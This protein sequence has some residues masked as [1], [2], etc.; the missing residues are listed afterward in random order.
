MNI[1]FDCEYIFPTNFTASS[2]YPRSFIMASTRALSI[3]AEAFLKSMYNRY[4][5]SV[6]NCASSNAAINSCNCLDVHLK[7]YFGP[8]SSI[9][10]LYLFYYSSYVYFLQIITT[11][12]I[13]SIS[14]L[15]TLNLEL[16]KFLLLMV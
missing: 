12:F 1:V 9:C 3:D 6:V 16:Y 14:D 15:V 13:L 11:L 5:S 4:M 10:D 8:F 2:G 7:R